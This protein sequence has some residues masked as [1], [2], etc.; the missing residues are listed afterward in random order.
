M[1]N[2]KTLFLASGLLVLSTSP[3]AFG[4]TLTSN[5]NGLFNFDNDVQL[6]N[7]TLSV[8]EMLEVFT[9][10]GATGGFPTN[11]A[12]FDGVGNMM[13]QGNGAP[14][15]NGFSTVNA[16]G[17]C[18]DA[19][20]A[21][22][23]SGVL[24]AGNYTVA[25]TQWDNLAIGNLTE[26]FFFVDV[27]PDP[28]FTFTNGNGCQAGTYFCDGFTHTNRTGNWAVTF[29]LINPNGNAVGTVTQAGATPE[30]AT[31]MLLMSGLGAGWW[32]RRRANRRA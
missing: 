25:L 27:V 12:M 3:N 32:I 1:L 16:D 19:Y 2:I 29:N 13:V 31:W 22:P 15:C 5:F 8:P 23:P 11:L 20:I 10:S 7:I 14:A 4:G 21:E 30:P 28:N 26:G 9:T 18:N 17:L 6:F 24:A